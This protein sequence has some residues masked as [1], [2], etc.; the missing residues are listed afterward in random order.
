MDYCKVT[1]K[2]TY[3]EIDNGLPQIATTHYHYWKVTQITITH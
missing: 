1:Q 2:T 3:E